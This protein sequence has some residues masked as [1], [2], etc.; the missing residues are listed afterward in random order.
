MT[1][2]DNSPVPVETPIEPIP[3]TINTPS[4]LPKRSIRAA[5]EAITKREQEKKRVNDEL[6]P[7][8]SPLPSSTEKK[9]ALKKKRKLNTKKVVTVPSSTSSPD[10]LGLENT[11][12]DSYS[13][14]LNPKEGRVAPIVIDIKK[15]KMVQRNNVDA[16]PST[17]NVPIHNQFDSLDLSHHSIIPN[18][19]Y[20]AHISLK[21]KLSVT[22]TVN[23][24][25][26]DSSVL[27]VKDDS[28]DEYFD[29]LSEFEDEIMEGVSQ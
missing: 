29:A 20:V 17:S 15:R 24:D 11:S 10:E 6:S 25:S 1:S 16:G 18:A 9:P 28:S 7:V 2:L 26:D 12:V 21:R 3:A 5:S 22:S 4:S 19:S 14:Y 8:S 27:S 23:G 13:K